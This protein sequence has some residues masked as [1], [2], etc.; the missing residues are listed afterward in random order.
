MIFLVNLRKIIIYCSLITICLVVGLGLYLYNPSIITS[1]SICN[2]EKDQIELK[3]KEIIDLRNKALLENNKKHLDNFYYLEHRH[4]LWAYEHNLMKMEYLQKWTQKQG[5][6]L[7]K[8]DSEVI[9][10]SAKRKEKDIGVSLLVSTEYKYVYEDEPDKENSFRLGAYHYLD[11]TPGEGDDKWVIK[12]Q[13]Y[14]DPLATVL[15]VD[16]DKIKENQEFVLTNEGDNLTDLNERRIMAVEYADKYCGAASLPQYEFKYN[17]EYINHNGLGGDCT[18]FASQV[19]YEGGKFSK[20]GA[21]NYKNGKGS[22]AWLNAHGFNNYMLY[23]G[24]ASR[25]AYGDYE[26]VFK[27]S[28]KLL[29]GDYIA[30]EEKGK[31]VHISVVTG[32]DSKGYTLVNSHNSDRFRVPWDIGWN[33]K[34]IKFSLVRVHY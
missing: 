16:P 7:K 33:I 28:F 34:G 8:I 23:S 22:K 4:G 2:V 20:D 10:K 3:I 11:I 13:W 32:R 6:Q 17:P 26:Q 31:V 15:D 27:P 9:L 1:T 21:W 14:L 12:R 18:N 5:I 19:L 24:K 29:P 30:Y 25:I